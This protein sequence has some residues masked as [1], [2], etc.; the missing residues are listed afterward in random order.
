MSACSD[1]QLLANEDSGWGA[2]LEGRQRQAARSAA[3][4]RPLD[5]TDL[6]SSYAESMTSPAQPS[7][8]VGLEKASH[9]HAR[10]KR[11]CRH[12]W[13][14]ALSPASIGQ[15]CHGWSGFQEHRLSGSRSKK[16]TISWPHKRLSVPIVTST[17]TCAGSLR[18]TVAAEQGRCRSTQHQN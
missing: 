16:Q 12:G 17:S 15:V 1:D 8:Q 7:P 4:P 5:P 3:I 11:L 2:Y 6:P 13:S 14:W 10:L 9:I 18:H